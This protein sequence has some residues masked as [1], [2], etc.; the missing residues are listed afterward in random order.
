MPFMPVSRDVLQRKCACGTHTMGG[1][2]CAECQKKKMGVGGRPL[3][4][5]LAIS[6][7]GDAYEQEADRVADQVMAAPV[8][9][10][11]SGGAFP[12]I[13]RFTEQST[14]QTDTTPASVDRV[15]RSAGRPLEVATQ[16]DMEQRFDHDFSQV[17]I[18]TGPAAEQSAGEV[19]ARAYTVGQN[20]VFGARQ[21][22]QGTIEGRHL[23][24][25][26]L[27]H[28]VQQASP[29]R[30][31]LH[32]SPDDE[33]G[34]ADEKPV[35]KFVGCTEDQ[36]SMIQGAIGQAENLASRAVQAFE[37]DI[38][39]SFESRAM[40][41]HF[42]SLGSG[43]KSTI[44]ER[45]K[46]IQTNLRNKTYS[47][48]KK[49]KKVKEGKTMVD[50]CGQASCPGSAITLFPGFGTKG[51]PVDTLILH[52]A[53]HN[54]G[55][56]D[57][58]DRGKKYPPANSQNNAYSYEYFAADVAAGY[59]EPPELKRHKPKAPEVGD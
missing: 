17:R 43:Q 19:N 26:E 22:S 48:A 37:R 57:D 20:I 38:P 51:C 59:K 24:A 10:S 47:C 31:M 18:H 29:A 56:C 12:A 25:H 4:T 46:H 15:L 36:Q 8:C 11:V 28:V 54:A 35:A 39:L 50:L 55:A 16:R 41:A 3:Q 42:G 7:P 6:E 52:E 45:Y 13:Q 21:F 33:K 23:I 58:I 44:V 34:K 53:A 49:G 32:R 27:T 14:G 2:Q 40:S 5:R 1:G 9:S 30:E